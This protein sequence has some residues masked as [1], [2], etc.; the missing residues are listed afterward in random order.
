MSDPMSKLPDGMNTYLARLLG[1]GSW[2][3]VGLIAVGMLMEALRLHVPV[4][5]ERVVSAGIVL[6]LALPPLGVLS[7]AIGFLLRKDRD[8]ALI[9]FVVLAITVA[10]I[11]FGV[12]AA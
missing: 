7:V 8:F 4:D 1:V 12:R 5:G 11:V 3:S 6:L 9:A 2:T 10:S